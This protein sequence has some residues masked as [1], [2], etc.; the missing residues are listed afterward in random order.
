MIVNNNRQGNFMMMNQSIRKLREVSETGYWAVCYGRMGLKVIPIYHPCDPAEKSRDKRGKRPIGSFVPHGFKDATDNVEQII[1]WWTRKPDA[2]IAIAPGSSGLI[3]IDIDGELGR[4][5]LVVLEKKLGTLPSTWTVTTGRENGGTH[6]YFK[7]PGFAVSNKV[8]WCDGIDIRHHGG[9]LIVPPSVH[10][11]GTRYEWL[12]SPSKTLLAELPEKWLNVLPKAGVTPLVGIQPARE[13]CLLNVVLP[14]ASPMQIDQCRNYVQK[15]QAAVSSNGG[16]NQT[17]AVARAIFYD[18]G[19]T[20]G[21]GWPI[22]VEYN[23][24]CEPPWSEY[25]L[26]HKMIDAQKPSHRPMGAAR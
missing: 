14:P 16:H 24:R 18:F 10:Q 15:C 25:E 13:G 17:F 23:Q 8:G 3:G 7:S 9:G 19:L 11:S 6:L 22:F 12:Y 21:E 2:N 20:E 4:Q 1:R 5:S 26:R